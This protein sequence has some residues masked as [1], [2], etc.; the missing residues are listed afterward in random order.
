MSYKWGT[1]MKLKAVLE[2]RWGKA[3]AQNPNS[4]QNGL[5]GVWIY[6][7]GGFRH[8]NGLFNCSSYQKFKTKLLA[9]PCSF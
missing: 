5:L 9:G 4:Y 6:V 8:R 1:L 2:A 7:Y 3:E